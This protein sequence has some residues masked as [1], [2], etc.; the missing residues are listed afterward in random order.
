MAISELRI[1]PPFA[2]ARLGYSPV[3]L[4]AYEL[5][6]DPAAPLDFRRLVPC[7]TL[8]V[9]AATGAIARSRVPDRIRFKDG[10]QIRPV[11]PFLEVYALTGENELE[12]LT[13]ELLAAEGLTPEHIHWSVKVG[14][15]KAHR[16]TGKDADR[17]Y[18]EIQRVNDHAEHALLGECAN[19]LPGKRLPLGRVRY[20]R[21]TKEFP[22][23]R[24]RFT[25]AAGRVYGASK[26]RKTAKNASEPDPILCDDDQIIYNP[27]GDWVGHF[28][29]GTP[30]DTNPG[31]I[32]AGY[33]DGNNQVSWGYLDDECD[34]VVTVELARKDGSPWLRA[35]GR[36]AAGPPAFA[37]DS[38][39]IRTV[40]DELEQILE[41]PLATGAVSPEVAIEIVRRALDS[42]RLMNT[43]A[44]N[45]NTI[46]G[47]TNIA[48]TMAR[49]DTND[50]GL[51]YGPIMAQS[52]VDQIALRALHERVLG[53]LQAGA[54]PWFA[55][56]LR[57]PEEIGDFSD[58]GRRKMPALMRG[59]DGRMLTL[60]R[61]HINQILQ[62][63]LAPSP[64]TP[65]AT[66]P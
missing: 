57:R 15:I 51:P 56:V 19:F 4:E 10:D 52:L 24:L 45:A 38:L 21:P 17:I 5:K 54:A 35:H 48:S 18:A 65:P 60:T 28:D 42:I 44:M 7:E 66:H 13:L 8:E 3:P 14:N 2:I 63:A 26:T 1:L 23:I 36:I 55:E 25:P 32:Y 27:K 47:R 29:K 46:G 53:A 6:V 40:L 50:Y 59:A 9:D 20:I 61:R 39:P 43:A 16:R 49:Q 64:A 58:Q 11:A 12:P 62:A 41:G 33:G 37:P 22:G 30:T 31:S 34:G